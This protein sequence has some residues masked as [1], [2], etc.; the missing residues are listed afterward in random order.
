MIKIFKVHL[1]YDVFIRFYFLPVTIELRSDQPNESLFP[2]RK[3]RENSQ[4][5]GDQDTKTHKVNDCPV[6]NLI[7]TLILYFTNRLEILN[8]VLSMLTRRS[9]TRQL[10]IGSS[11]VQQP[12]IIY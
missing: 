5:I 1:S 8:Q 3:L 7:Y 9:E 10:V 6:Y 11:K 4:Q 12:R 2:E